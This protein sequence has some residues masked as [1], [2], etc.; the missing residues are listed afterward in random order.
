MTAFGGRLFTAADDIDAA[1]PAVVLS[2]HAWRLT[3]AA[4]LL[5][6]VPR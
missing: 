4:I 1:P 5:S 6:S 2:H 3:Y